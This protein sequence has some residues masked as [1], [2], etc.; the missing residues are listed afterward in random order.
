MI[1]DSDICP[2]RASWESFL[3]GDICTEKQL[4]M[5]SHLDSCADCLAMLNR[6]EDSHSIRTCRA[7]T[8]FPYLAE[9]NFFRL[10]AWVENLSSIG[11][12]DESSEVF[13]AELPQRFGR[14]EV[15]RVLGA[16]AFAGQSHVR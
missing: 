5:C 2:P 12:N 13:E 10:L 9:D 11:L 4:E 8:G 14:F 15:E 6:I 16:G 1:L 3:L 7:L